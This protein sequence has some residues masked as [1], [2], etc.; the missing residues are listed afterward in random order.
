MN[1]EDLIKSVDACIWG[2]SRYENAGSFGQA[3]HI[4]TLLI[5]MA[6]IREQLAEGTPYKGKLFMP[7]EIIGFDLRP[8]AEQVAEQ[9]I[10]DLN[11]D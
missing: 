9:I 6:E 8:S 7:D 2:M 3:V 5:L 4:R 1:K 10:K 11:N